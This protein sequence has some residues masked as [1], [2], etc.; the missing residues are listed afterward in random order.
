MI[1]ERINSSTLE[2]R[3][4]NT[5]LH[6]R[7]PADTE[8]QSK[9]FNTELYRTNILNYAH[10]IDYKIHHEYKFTTY[11]IGI[12]RQAATTGSITRRRPK[13]LVEELQ[14]IE[15]RLTTHWAPGKWFCRFNQ[16]ST[17]DGICEFPF[18]TPKNVIDSICT[19]ARAIGCFETDDT[20]LFVV[21][22][23]S[24]ARD[25]EVRCFVRHR[26]LTAISQY[27]W[28]T[29]GYFGGLDGH[30]LLQIARRIDKFVSEHIDPLCDH[31]QTDDLVIDLY[32]GDSDIKIIEL[33]SFGYWLSTGSALFNWITDKS[34]LYGTT[35]S[36]HMRVLD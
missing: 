13:H 33:N 19:S 12:L 35:D 18:T 4:F 20:L 25:R 5:S 23:D 26:R 30:K 15:D 14:E 22:N 28:F 7:D 32:I 36:I 17:K 8:A 29:R 24:W 2:E 31:L 16:C 21:H 10:L 27:Y 3:A 11:E 9:D 1:I 6:K 34:K